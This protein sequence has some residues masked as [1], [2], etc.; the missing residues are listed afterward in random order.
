MLDAECC[1][2][3]DRRGFLHKKIGGFAKGLLGIGSG[4]LPGPLG[5]IAGFGSKLLGGG[6]SRAAAGGGRSFGRGRG[7]F[8]PG[9]R[10]QIPTPGLGGR[11]QRFLPGGGTGF[12]TVDPRFFSGGRGG[13]ERVPADIRNVLE[14][15]QRMR[16][17]STT[18]GLCPDEPRICPPRGFHLNKSSYFLRDGTFVERG[19]VFVRNRR[20]NN[21]NG[22]A[23]AKAITRLEK[24]ADNAKKLLKA[25]GFRTISKQSSRELRMRR[26]GH[27]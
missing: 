10:T 26:R 1:R 6:G 21:A 12:T 22:Q 5:G 27:R 15:G 11:I 13:G 20:L 9:T 16:S 4:L 23:Q 14:A 25:T 8:P 24:G 7:R 18:N 2:P 19:T 17:G 3:N